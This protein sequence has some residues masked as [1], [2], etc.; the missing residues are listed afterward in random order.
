MDAEDTIFTKIVRGELPA[1]KIYED[2]RTLAFLSIYPAVTGHTLVIPKVQIASLWAL[3]D[4]DYVAV[5]RTAKRVAL[6]LKDVLAVERIGER[7]IG[8]DV[9][10]AHVH[11]IP[12]NTPEEYYARETKD[13]PDHEALAALAQ[14][15]FFTD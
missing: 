12:F 15:L 7:V 13:E 6:R 9:P 8:V 11:L 3:N 1:H 5:M 10:H 4:E 2:E 14:R